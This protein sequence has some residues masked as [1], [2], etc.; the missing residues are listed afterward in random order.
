M[1]VNDYDLIRPDYYFERSSRFNVIINRIQDL[2]GDL[3]LKYILPV[4]TIY[5]NIAALRIDYVR[6]LVD[7]WRDCPDGSIIVIDEIQLV[8]PYSDTKDKTNP[9]VTNLSIHRHRRFYF[10]F[11][12]QSAGNFHVLI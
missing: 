1:A 5:S 7:D 12:T 9:I 3:G 4:R 11:I 10:Y 6:S 8:S 2:H